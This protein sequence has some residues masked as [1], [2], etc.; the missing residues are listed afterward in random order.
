MGGIN[1]VGVSEGIDTWLRNKKIMR[2]GS[3]VTLV[4]FEVVFKT[5]AVQTIDYFKC[6]ITVQVRPSVYEW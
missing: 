5:N 3:E 4:L 6:L 2:V 1:K